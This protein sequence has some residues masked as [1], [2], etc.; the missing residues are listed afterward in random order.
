MSPVTVDHLIIGAGTSGCTVAGGLAAS[1]DRSVLVLEAGGADTS[2]RT[3]VPAATKWMYGRPA[4]DWQHAS[5]ADPSLNGR[6]ERWAAGRVVG[7]SSTINGTIYVRGSAQDFDAWRDAGNPGWGHADLL[8]LFRQLEGTTIG[9]GARRG[10]GGPLAVAWTRSRHPLAQATASAMRAAGL[11][12]TEDFN[13]EQFEGAG[14]AQV[15]QRDGVRVSAARAFLHPALREG[16]HPVRL[17][18]GAHCVGLVVEGGRCTGARFVQRGELIQV[19][20]LR[21]V[22][23]CAGAV[24][25]PQLLMLSGIGP[26]AVLSALG[27]R[28]HGDLPGVGQGLME[29]PVLK[30]SARV[31]ASTYNVETHPLGALRHLWRYLRHRDGLLASPHAQLLAHV[32]S[33]PA[34]Q[35][36]DVQ[37]AFYPYAFE[38]SEGGVRRARAPAVMFTVMVSQGRGRG[39]IALASADPHAPPVIRHALLANDADRQTLVAGCRLVHRIA[40]QAPLAAEIRT[41]I[42]IDPA[43]AG[44]ADWTRYLDAETAL[45]YHPAGSCRMGS[46]GQAVVDAGLRVRGIEGL[47]VADNSIM[48]SPVSGNAQA[49]AYIIGAKAA[50]LILADTADHP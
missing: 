28:V 20:A 13:G 46:D 37:I 50:A 49:A 39:E 3:L 32:R 2:L 47:R 24:K 48:P 7:G 38:R 1:G 5:R 6:A 4:Y 11:P 16:R 21:G 35:R 34:V 29:H 41:W 19:N 42:E 33:T 27:I 25:S 23:L 30:L 36:P 12:W 31:H 18:T 17:L 22:V 26:G 14:W 45:A 15:T 9:D 44:A 40:S 43:S 8:P 10:R